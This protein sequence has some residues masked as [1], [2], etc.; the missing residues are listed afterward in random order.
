M[1]KL[2]KTTLALTLVCAIAIWTIE[3][4]TDYSIELN[5]KDNH[6]E[7]TKAIQETIDNLIENN[8]LDAAQFALDELRPT[9]EDEGILIGCKVLQSLIDEKKKEL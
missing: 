1:K 2:I 8:Y 6:V 5:Y 7:R 3:T 9:L 4:F